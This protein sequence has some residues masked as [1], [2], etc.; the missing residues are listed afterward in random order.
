ML[1]T[2]VGA[3]V[4]TLRDVAKKPTR[5]PLSICMFV[6]MFYKIYTACTRKL[7]R[8]MDSY[9]KHIQPSGVKQFSYCWRRS[10]ELIKLLLSQ[11]ISALR[12]YKK[13]TCSFHVPQNRNYETNRQCPECALVRE[14]HS[15]YN[16]LV[17]VVELWCAMKS[18][19]PNSHVVFI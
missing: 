12:R 11:L 6:Q 17:C 5:Y 9:L 2:V 10:L 15:N 7:R 18:R 19:Y 1:S 4:T 14:S 16:Y 13:Y 8:S 3:F